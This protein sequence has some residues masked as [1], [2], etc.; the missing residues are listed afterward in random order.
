MNKVWGTEFWIM[1]ALT[2]TCTSFPF[3]YLIYNLPPC[4]SLLYTLIVSLSHVRFTSANTSAQLNLFLCD[5]YAYFESPWVWHKTSFNAFLRESFQC[6]EF[7]KTAF[8]ALF[9]HTVIHLLKSYQLLWILWIASPGTRPSRAFIWTETGGEL[10]EEPNRRSGPWDPLAQW[11]HQHPD[12]RAGAQRERSSAGAQWGQSADQV[13]SC[14]DIL[15]LY[16]AVLTSITGLSV[17]W[18]GRQGTYSGTYSD[19]LMAL[20]LL[21]GTV[22]YRTVWLT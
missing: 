20:F 11:D 19:N 2:V 14:E 13:P 22:Q 18:L 7:I 12:Q 10:L 6:N 1:G 21:H 15:T 16:E 4:L 3:S 5:L 17:T 9:R 8:A